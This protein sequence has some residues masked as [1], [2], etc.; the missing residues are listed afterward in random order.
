MDRE[1]SLEQAID[2]TIAELRNSSNCADAKTVASFMVLLDTIVES[3]HEIITLR[4][5]LKLSIVLTTLITSGFSEKYPTYYTH[6]TGHIACAVGFYCY[7]KQL[8][9]NVSVHNIPTIIVLL[10]DGQRYMLDI[11][12]DYL[13]ST[14]SPYNPFDQYDIENIE[15]K[16]R[17]IVKGLEYLMHE[18]YNEYGLYDNEL[19]RWKFELQSEMKYIKQRIGNDYFYYAQKLYEFLN[20]KFQSSNPFCFTE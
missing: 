3:P 7:M 4:N 13:L 14:L 19:S 15:D 20:T 16:K 1:L 10:H 18:T 5:P 11:I 12:E 2:I 9:E 17:A 6:N 8:K